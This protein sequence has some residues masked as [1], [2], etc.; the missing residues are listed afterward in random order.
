MLLLEKLKER[1]PHHHIQ[2]MYDIACTLK[3]HLM[4]GKLF[5]FRVYPLLKTC[6]ECWSDLRERTELA[7]PVFHAY[8][9]KMACQVRYV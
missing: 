1:F 2:F 4:V 8:G 5:I 3:K 7:I 9:H 6:S